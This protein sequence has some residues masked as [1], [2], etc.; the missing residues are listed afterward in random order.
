MKRVLAAM[1]ATFLLIYLSTVEA[2]PEE[3]RKPEAS[4]HAEAIRLVM[5]TQQA[6]IR[7][8]DQGNWWH[9]VKERAWKAKRPFA[10]GGFDS[11]HMFVVS[12]HIDGKAVCSW[13]VDTRAGKVQRQELPEKK[14]GE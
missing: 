14:A 5:T 10:P 4:P 1:T 8:V 13:S 2:D 12:Y 7:E 6:T 9:D 3:R 11:T